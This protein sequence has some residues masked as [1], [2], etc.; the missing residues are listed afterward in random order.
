MLECSYGGLSL[1][2]FLQSP[3]LIVGISAMHSGWFPAL[4]LS[5]SDSWNA[6]WIPAGSWQSWLALLPQPDRSLCW[7]GI[8]PEIWLYCQEATV[9]MFVW[10]GRKT[11]VYCKMVSAVVPYSGSLYLQSIFWKEC[12]H[13]FD[14]V[15]V[16]TI[17]AGTNMAVTRTWLS[18]LSREHFFRQS[19]VRSNQLGVLFIAT[20]FWLLLRWLVLQYSL[21][22][23]SLHCS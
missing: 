14:A 13:R 1:Q 3:E 20:V 4:Q 18:G 11:A 23:D 2:P 12:S 19:A 6:V 21:V 9:K 22:F 8:W 5:F 15:Y 10:D 17:D 7:Y 16:A